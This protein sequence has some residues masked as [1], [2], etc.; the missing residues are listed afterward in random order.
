V[1]REAPDLKRHL[2]GLR[3]LESSLM[4]RASFRAAYDTLYTLASLQD[5]LT[6]YPNR[7]RTSDRAALVMAWM[8]AQNIKESAKSQPTENG[9]DAADLE[10]AM[11]DCIGAAERLIEDMDCQIQI[12]EAYLKV[13]ERIIDKLAVER[14]LLAR[15][16]QN[17]PGITWTVE[18]QTVTMG[19]A[20]ARVLQFKANTDDIIK[21][22]E[23]IIRDENK[24]REDIILLENK[25]LKMH[26]LLMGGR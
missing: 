21:G 23:E 18:G 25:V 7:S 17:A 5:D 20:V 10:L 13:A 8:N 19:I 3:N 4:P 16:Q 14:R 9:K 6:L 1:V 11:H 26:S 12:S 22:R 24:I 15:L 2:D